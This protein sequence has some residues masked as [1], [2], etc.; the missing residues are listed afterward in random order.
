MDVGEERI[1]VIPLRKVKEAPKKKRSPRAMREV[2]SFLVRHTKT[3]DVVL[4][5]S[6]N[7]HVWS[8]GIE[9]PPSKVRVRA[10]KEE[11]E[12]EESKIIRVNA[13]LAE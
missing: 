6:I 4:D 11:I 9:K 10:V 7:E 12:K 5:K 8:R 13:F 2:R 1:Y 3:D